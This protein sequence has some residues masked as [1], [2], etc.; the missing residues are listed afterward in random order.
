MPALSWLRLAHKSGLVTVLGRLC[1]SPARFPALSLSSS[2]SKAHDVSS[3]DEPL[4]TRWACMPSGPS[5]SHQLLLAVCLDITSSREPSLITFHS[6]QHTGGL[7]GPSHCPQ[8]PGSLSHT[9]HASPP[10]GVLDP[11][12]SHFLKRRIGCP[13]SRG[14]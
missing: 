1:H 6:P 10:P 4:L 13:A 12:W 3:L 5:C 14:S 7:R 9:I 2:A 8:S 11:T